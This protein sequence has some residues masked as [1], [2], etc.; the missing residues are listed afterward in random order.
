MTDAPTNYDL[1]FAAGIK[2]AD[3]IALTLE[4]KWRNT[5]AKYRTRKRWFFGWFTDPAYDS[6]A[7]SVE[8]AADGIAAIRKVLGWQTP[9]RR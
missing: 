8:A 7:K 1:G 9:T 3:E 4:E 2:R 6:A 5:A